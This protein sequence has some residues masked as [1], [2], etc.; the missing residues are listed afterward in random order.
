LE[1]WA[2]VTVLRTAKF[3]AAKFKLSIARVVGRGLWGWW[4]EVLKEDVFDCRSEGQ[5]LVG[6]DGREVGRG[7]EKE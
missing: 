3:G 5:Y 2:W 7:G 1:A 4:L 6:G